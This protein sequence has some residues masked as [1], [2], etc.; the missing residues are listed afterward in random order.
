MV[1]NWTLTIA[2]IL[3]V[4]AVNA[5]DIH[6]TQ[7]YFSPL[8]TNPAYTGNFDGDYRIVGNHRSQWGAV[9]T[10]QFVTSGLSYDQNIDIYNHQIAVGIHFIHDQ[11][12]IGFLNQ[13][14]LEIAGSYKKVINGH[15]LAGGIQFGLLHKGLNFN[16]FTFPN[17]FNMDDGYFDQSVSNNQDFTTNNI[18]R[19]DLNAGISWSKQV[20]DKLE[21]IVGFSLLHINTPKETFLNNDTNSFPLR[22][23]FDFKMKYKLSDKN[24]L[25]PTMIYMHQN[26]AHEIVWGGMIRHK[27]ATNKYQLFDIFGGF[28]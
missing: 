17:Q 28:S 7:Y 18:Y 6:F 26:K 8:N 5:Q 14:K 22:K 25:I 11:S 1:K 27:V 10:D 19:L 16:K 2:L 24:T 15:K 23:L 20:S 3:S 4:F 12:S 13:N 9:V 21:P